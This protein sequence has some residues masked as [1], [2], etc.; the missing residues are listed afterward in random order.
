MI[1]YPFC[2]VPA[3]R[4]WFLLAFSR[5]RRFLIFAL[6][7]HAMLRVRH[8]M[9]V[10]GCGTS[11]GSS[12]VSSVGIMRVRLCDHLLRFVRVDETGM[13]VMAGTFCPRP[14]PPSLLCL[15]R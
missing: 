13:G 11:R 1:P 2:A 6:A 7:F 9:M 12:C 15:A 14:A 10:I 8:S 5:D 3:I 4:L